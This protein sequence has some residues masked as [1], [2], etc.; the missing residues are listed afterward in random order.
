MQHKERPKSI[1]PR[2]VWALAVWTLAAMLDTTGGYAV[3]QRGNVALKG[4]VVDPQGAVV[5][6]ASV[7]ATNQETKVVK[8][9]ISTSAGTYVFPSLLPGNYTIE[10]DANGFSKF[11]RKDVTVLSGQDNEANVAVKVSGSTETVEVV[12]GAVLV[13]TT[14]PMLTNNYDA[15]SICSLP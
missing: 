2:L 4:Q 14:S 8:S 13:Q 3:A 15:T 12:A 5:G 10:V 1:L 7:T 11:S 6:G 9:T